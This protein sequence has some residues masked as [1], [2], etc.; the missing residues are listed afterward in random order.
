MGVRSF[1]NKPYIK[2][3]VKMDLKEITYGVGQ[4]LFKQG[5]KGGKLYFIK[6]G[7]VELLVKNSENSGEAV[8]AKV[9]PQSVLGTMTFLENEPRSA[10]AKVTEEVKCLEVNEIMREKLLA[11]VPNWFK[12]L[13]KDLSGNLRNLNNEYAIAV[14]K[15]NDVNRKYEAALKRIESLENK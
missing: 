10:T 6:S 1:H 13:L 8:V 12:V 11:S 7:E 9:G 5:E 4:V 2:I 14:T 15:L 3:E